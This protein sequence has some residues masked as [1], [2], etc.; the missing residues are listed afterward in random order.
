MVGIWIY[1]PA[2]ILIGL[3]IAPFRSSY[4]GGREC[5]SVVVAY[6]I[7]DLLW[8]LKLQRKHFIGSHQAVS[9]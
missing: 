1:L 5:S 3:H 8:D 2:F 7:P 6:T 9:S 4:F